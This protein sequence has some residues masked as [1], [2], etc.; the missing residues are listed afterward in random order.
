MKWLWL[1]TKGSRSARFAQLLKKILDKTELT[2]IS[3]KSYDNADFENF[4]R[5]SQRKKLRNASNS[6]KN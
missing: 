6:F 1:K 5:K 4:L 2:K 3:G